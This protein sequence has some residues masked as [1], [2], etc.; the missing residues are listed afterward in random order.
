M[1]DQEMNQ[2]LKDATEGVESDLA[3]K[4]PEFWATLKRQVEEIGEKG[5]IVSGFND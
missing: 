4:Y 5:G 1:S 2:M 3:S